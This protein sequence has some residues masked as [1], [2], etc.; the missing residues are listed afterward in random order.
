[1]VSTHNSVVRQA[2]GTMD[3]I[4]TASVVHTTAAR[5]QSSEFIRAKAQEVNRLGQPYRVQ[6]TPR[7]QPHTTAADVQWAP[8]RSLLSEATLRR[9]SCHR[10]R[11][12]PR[13]HRRSRRWHSP[14]ALP[15]VLHEQQPLRRRS[16]RRCYRCRGRWHPS[17]PD[18]LP[19][20][21]RATLFKE[22]IFTC[23]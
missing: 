4:A 16:C 2:Q 20:A 11:R 15:Y 22:A 12:H 9:A 18:P 14:A 7:E 8:F 10:P 6:A 3:L 21:V 5:V 17:L 23:N 19:D 13:P 1:M